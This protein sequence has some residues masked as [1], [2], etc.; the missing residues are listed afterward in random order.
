MA[1]VVYVWFSFI[2]DFQFQVY[3]KLIKA[4]KRNSAY[5]LPELYKVKR[6]KLKLSFCLLI[7][8]EVKDKFFRKKLIFNFPQL[9]K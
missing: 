4:H 1:T 2:L 9:S 6:V 3:Q 8:Q 7:A 5:I